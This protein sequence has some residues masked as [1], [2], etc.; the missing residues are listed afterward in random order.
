M[1]FLGT[2]C[3]E[4][5]T[6]GWCTPTGEKGSRWETSGLENTNWEDFSNDGFTGRSCPQ[7]G[8]IGDHKFS[9]IGFSKFI[10]AE[11]GF[12]PENFDIFDQNYRSVGHK[13]GRDFYETFSYSQND[14]QNA[15]QIS[16]ESSFEAQTTRND[17]DWK[18]ASGWVIKK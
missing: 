8:C 14:E 15:V 1:N 13:N 12:D 11:W 18:I 17:I 5:K 7:C 6:E 9:L 10:Q 3:E 2:T 16:W 4:Y